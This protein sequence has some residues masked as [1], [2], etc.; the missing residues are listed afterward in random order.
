MNEIGYDRSD[1]KEYK[2]LYGMEIS[3]A[4][5][6]LLVN[7]IGDDKLYAKGVQNYI[8]WKSAQPHPNYL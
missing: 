1:A 6:R 3:S 4:T 2:I 8:A 5:S 7:V